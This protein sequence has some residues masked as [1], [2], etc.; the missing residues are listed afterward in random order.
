MTRD[1]NEAHVRFLNAEMVDITSQWVTWPEYITFSKNLVLI[2]KL[3]ERAALDQKS[4]AELARYWALRKAL[5]GSPLHPRECFDRTAIVEGFELDGEL[6]VALSRLRESVKLLCATDNPMRI[7]MLRHHSSMTKSGSNQTER[8]YLLV[9]FKSVSKVNEILATE[10]F[11]SSAV[12]ATNLRHLRELEAA[13]I[14]FVFGA[15]ENHA[16]PYNIGIEKSREVAWLFN[17]PAARRVVIYQLGDSPSFDS[18]LYE[19]WPESNQFRAKSVGVKPLVFVENFEPA[20]RIGPIDEP[21]SNPGDPVVEAVVVHLFNGRYIYYSDVVPPKPT[22]VRS[23]EI[24]I[25]IDDRVRASSLRP[26]DVL[27]IRTGVASHSFLRSHAKVWLTERYGD[28]DTEEMFKIVDTYKKSLQAKYD[29]SNFI[30]NL[31]SSGMEEGYL[32]NQIL[33]AFVGST[34]ATQKSENFIHISRALGLDYGPEEWSAILNLQTAHRQAGHVA[35][36][37]LRDIVRE[38]DSWQDVVSE[39]GIA[40][41]KAGS[42]GEMVLIP[43]VQK[44]DQ[45]VRVSVSSLGQ[46]LHKPVLFHG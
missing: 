6:G 29:D 42:I 33:K 34:I 14:L 7:E 19:I 9:Y 41:L 10:F 38:N 27:L 3:G 2:S 20:L 37:E 32:R 4:R 13:E 26:G 23:D 39:P 15:P 44:P 17:S 5:R 28:S 31:V 8:A 21:A 1:L 46:L 18:S 25:E 45:I 22:C 36:Q 35:S 43:V 40:K 24:E 12:Q 30:R 16:Y 11:N